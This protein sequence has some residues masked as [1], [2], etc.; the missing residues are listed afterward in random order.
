MSVIGVYTVLSF[1]RFIVHN[2]VFIMCGIP[3]SPELHALLFFSLS[4]MRL[5]LNEGERLKEKVQ[6][7]TTFASKE[8]HLP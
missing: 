3:V 8:P 2:S 7:S 1:L 6:W 4:T 5:M